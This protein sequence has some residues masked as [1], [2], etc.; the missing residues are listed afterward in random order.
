MG[1]D[2]QE[3][4]DRSPKAYMLPAFDEYIIGYKDRS[5]VLDRLHA[6][7]LVPGNNG[8]SCSPCWLTERW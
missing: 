1:N 2:I 4:H 7:R 5:A 3:P 8:M 6:S